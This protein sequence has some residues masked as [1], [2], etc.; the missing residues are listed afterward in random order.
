MAQLQRK[1][2]LAGRPRRDRL[3][4]RGRRTSVPLDTESGQ[5]R[6]EFWT[7]NNVT[8]APVVTADTVYV[9]SDDTI[10]YAFDIDSGERR[11]EFD[12]TGR[13]DGA[14]GAVVDGRL[15]ISTF[16]DGLYALEGA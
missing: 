10:I 15:Y 16:Q 14:G 5:Q 6:W 1:G 3:Y 13:I 12:T 2:V 11:W 9:G 4:R 7:W 8:G